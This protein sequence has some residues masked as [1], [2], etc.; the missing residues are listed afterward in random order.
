MIEQEA[1]PKV[2]M[3]FGLPQQIC[4]MLQEGFV[5]NIFIFPVLVSL[6]SQ[7][8]TN[9]INTRSRQT[10]TN[11]HNK[12]WKIPNHKR[13]DVSRKLPAVTRLPGND[14]IRCQLFLFKAQRPTEMATLGRA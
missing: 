7:K 1:T 14:P 9:P 8:M 6:K 4:R 12:I 13:H 10:A 5:W 3:P 11:K 2:Q